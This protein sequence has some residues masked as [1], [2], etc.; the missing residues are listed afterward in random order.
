MTNFPAC[1]QCSETLTYSD[2]QLFIC[3]MCGHEWTQAEMDAAEEAAIVRDVNGN[4]LKDGDNV[5]VHQDIKVSGS[6][7]IKQGTKIANIR[8]LLEPVNEHDIECR[9]DGFGRMYL[10]S[11][12]VKK[13]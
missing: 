5:I 2:G 11:S 13:N 4:P 8:V 6:K 3:P 1:P 9:V 10:K 7:K 12:L